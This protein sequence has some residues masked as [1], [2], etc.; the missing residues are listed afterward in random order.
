MREFLDYLNG[1]TN[2]APLDE[3]LKWQCRLEIGPDEL[4]EFMQ[5]DAQNY[6]RNLVKEGPYYRVLVLCWGCRTE[7]SDSRSCRFDVR[8]AGD[9]RRGQRDDLSASRTRSAP[10]HEPLG[11]QRRVWRFGR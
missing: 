8:G 6:K 10:T 1:L 2:R 7:Q 5:F 4:R 3:L 9:P 11:C